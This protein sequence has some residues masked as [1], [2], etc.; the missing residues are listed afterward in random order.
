[1]IKV[2]IC[3]LLNMLVAFNF[4]PLALAVSHN[5]MKLASCSISFSQYI[6]MSSAIPIVFGTSARALS[7]LS[8]KYI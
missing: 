6:T 3:S 1:M 7:S 4:N 8:L 2:N 5:V